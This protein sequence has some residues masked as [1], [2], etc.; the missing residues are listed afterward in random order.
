MILRLQS[1]F[2]GLLAVLLAL[3]AAQAKPTSGGYQH[4]EPVALEHQQHIQLSSLGN[5]DYFAKVA[6]ECCNATN[7]GAFRTTDAVSVTGARS[8]DK[9]QSYETGVREIYGGASLSDRS[10]TVIVD[11]RR[12]NGIADDVTVINGRTTAVD[13]KFT[14]DWATS[15]RNP[16][17]PNGNQPWAVA[18]QQ[19]M[20]DQARNYSVAFDGGAIYH[21]NNQALAQHYARA[22]TDAGISNFEFVVTPT[23]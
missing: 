1:F 18:E 13:A 10:F 21:T 19:K 8:I 16:N 2:A 23:R 4:F 6:S 7:K 20:V 15:I 5:F 9:A 12:V 11:G 3:G 22:F 14:D 17:S